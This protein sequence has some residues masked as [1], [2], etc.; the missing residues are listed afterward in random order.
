[1]ATTEE[2]I[3]EMY[4][5]QLASKKAQLQQDHETNNAALDA[6]QQKNQK[7]TD[8]N[9][10]RTAVEAQKDMMNDAEYYAA[11]GLEMVQKRKII[12]LF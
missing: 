2:K 11:S 1:M 4:D 10:N 8:V 3:T 12:Q 5:A 9:L 7:A 6:A